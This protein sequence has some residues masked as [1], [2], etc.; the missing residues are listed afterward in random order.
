MARCSSCNKFVSYGDPEIELQDVTLNTH[1]TGGCV[2]V[3]AEVKLTCSDCSE[4]VKSATISAE[5]EFSH[6]CSPETKA[7]FEESQKAAGEPPFNEESGEE[8]TVDDEQPDCE[9][10]DRQQ[11]TDRH[12]KPI[13]NPRYRRQYYGFTTTVEV[14]CNRCGEVISVDL[15]GEEQASGFEETY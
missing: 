12:G 6:E 8:F 5:Q 13:K 4:A 2:T 3:E 10:T 11:T 9:A 7:E 1:E 14:K 15:E